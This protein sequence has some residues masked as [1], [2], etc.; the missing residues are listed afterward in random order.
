MTDKQRSKKNYLTETII[1]CISCAILTLFILDGVKERS[2]VSKTV[3]NERLQNYEP[4]NIRL[5]DVN[6]DGL[7]DII[8]KTG[9]IYLQT[10]KGTF[11]SYDSI[12][13]QEKRRTDSIYKQRKD[14]ILKYTN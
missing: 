10:K 5:K 7:Q 9:E 12:V 1:S 13:A 6:K 4:K 8:Y 11:V 14:S 2:Y 3:E